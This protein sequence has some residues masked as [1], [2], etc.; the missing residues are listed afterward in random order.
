M[1]KLA[2]VPVS[3][4]MLKAVASQSVKQG[5]NLRNQ[6]RDMTLQAL[7]AREASLDHVKQAFQAVTQGVNIG[8]VTPVVDASKALTDMIHGIDNAVLKAVHANQ[9]ALEQFTTQASEFTQ[10]YLKRAVDELE[11]V[12]GQFMG[13]M[14]QTADASGNKLT[15]QWNEALKQVKLPGVA[16]GQEFALNVESFQSQMSAAVHETRL[17]SLKAVETFTRNYFTLASGILSGFSEALEAKQ[18]ER[19]KK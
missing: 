1:A 14:K 19:K 17:A 9:L 12:E 4:E 18:A 6:V 11:R 10:T 3:D 2:I 5:E 16:T 13:V 15:E 7:N 8:G